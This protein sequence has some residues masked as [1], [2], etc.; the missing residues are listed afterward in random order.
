ME[1]ETS[2]G[3]IEQMYLL[4]F[5]IGFYNK[6]L[7]NAVCLVGDNCNVKKSFV[8]NAL[9]LHCLGFKPLQPCRVRNSQIRRG[10]SVYGALMFKCLTVIAA[11]KCAKSLI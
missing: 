10:R 6:T 1:D 2:Q 11:E 3:S 8:R 4:N 9:D 7:D 5:V